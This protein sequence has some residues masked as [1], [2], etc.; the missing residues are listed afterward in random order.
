MKLIGMYTGLATLMLLAQL[1][2]QTG[3]QMEPKA[4]AAGTAIVTVG[5]VN[6]ARQ[7]GS[8][9]GGPGV[10]PAANP[11]TAADLANS[12][13]L[14]GVLLLNGATAANATKDTRTRAAAG[15]TVREAPVIYVLDG[16]RQ[17]LE[18]HVGHQVEV[19]GTLRVVKEGPPATQ[20]TISHIQVAS[21]TMLAGSC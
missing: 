14:T 21:V 7:N 5:C 15:D 16:L 10:P 3:G 9:S 2:A 12:Q 17:E 1:N 13:E 19:T 18:R 11:A 8:A 4:P 20:S 6:R